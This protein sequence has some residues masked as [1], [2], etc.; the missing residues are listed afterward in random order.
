MKT[1]EVCELGPTA[2]V[3]AGYRWAAPVLVGPD[4][5]AAGP[6]GCLTFILEI[7]AELQT[8]TVT[9]MVEPA[10]PMPV[11]GATTLWM[12]PVAIGVLGLGMVIVVVVVM[13]ARLRRA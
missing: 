9:N 3:P 5:E 4:G 2:P 7:D 1:V 10:P 6:D 12:L 8:V 13:R 11:T